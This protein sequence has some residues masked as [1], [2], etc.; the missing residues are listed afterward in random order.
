MSR[1]SPKRHRRSS[2]PYHLIVARGDE[3]RSVLVRKWMI[4]LASFAGIGVTFWLC[5]ATAY[6]M[7]RD[8]VLS[9]MMS[10]QTRMQHAYEDRIAQLRLQIDRVTSRQLLDQEAFTVRLDEVLRRQQALEA[11]AQVINGAVERARQSGITVQPPDPTVTGSIDPRH[12]TPPGRV[13]AIDAM[14]GAIDRNIGVMVASQDHVLAQIETRARETENRMRSAIAD[15]GVDPER[16]A[17]PR[18]RPQ[19]Q[20]GPFVPLVGVGL[21]PFQHRNDTLADQL[22]WIDRLRRG[23]GPLPVRR[24]VAE[25]DISSGF[26][27]RTDPFLGTPA[28]HAGLDF[29]GTTGD[30][31]R[32]TGAGTVV[33]AG[34]S[35]GFGLM[36]EIDHGHDLTTRYAHLSAIGVQEGQRVAAGQ[37]IGRLGSTG[38]STGPHLHWETRLDGEAIDPARFMRAGQRL[39]IW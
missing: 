10:R 1:R 31:V 26:G 36:V 2:E 5:A 11:R 39:G 34:R 6:V 12:G 16:L 28:L 38:R 20:R 18:P 35:G 29:R 4:V 15:L 21:D 9:S 37:V 32:A 3:V 27:P 33:S 24:P 19:A 23:L 8:D 14:L 13:A 22:G 25:V 17:G 30:P 7:F